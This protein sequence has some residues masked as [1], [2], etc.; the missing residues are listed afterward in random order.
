M[1][2]ALVRSTPFESATLVSTNLARSPDRSTAS[3]SVEPVLVPSKA[4]MAPGCTVTTTLPPVGATSASSLP[5]KTR[6]RKT[7]PSFTSKASETKAASRPAATRAAT[8][9]PVGVLENSTVS[10][11]EAATAART[12]FVQP[13]TL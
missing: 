9:Q 11:F 12:A 1:I 5:L 7:G 13:S 2:S 6:R 4:A 8:S 10:A 3:F